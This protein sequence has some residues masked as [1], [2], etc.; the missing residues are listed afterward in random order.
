MLELPERYRKLLTPPGVATL[1]VLARDGTI[2]S[3]LVWADFDGEFIKLNVSRGSPKERNIQR[4]GKA[5]VLAVDPLDESFYVS[6]RCELHKVSADGA[7]EHLNVLT[8]HNMGVSRWY[9]DVEPL[10]PAAESLRVIVYLRP[11]RVYHT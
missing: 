10:D 8:K 4:E 2:Q 9:G 3:T 1:S 5:T 7:I 6:L 11:V